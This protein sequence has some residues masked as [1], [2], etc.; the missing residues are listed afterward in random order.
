VGVTAPEL[1]DTDGNPMA[2]T[3]SDGTI[4]VA[5][6]RE[7]LDCRSGVTALDALNLIYYIA[8]LPTTDH[9]SGCPALGE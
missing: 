2:A 6:S 7:D 8:G 3:L 1:T 4:T 9:A 5:V